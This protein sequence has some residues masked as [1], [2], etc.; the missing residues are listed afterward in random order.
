M[1]SMQWNVKFVFNWTFVLGPRETTEALDQLDRSQNFPDEKWL[2]A[3]SP[4]IKH[5]NHNVTLHLTL[6]SF[7]KRHVFVLYFYE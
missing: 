2:L 4:A 5:T 1:W 6:I 7:E 3:E